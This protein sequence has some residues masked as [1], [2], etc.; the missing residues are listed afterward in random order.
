MSMKRPA[1]GDMAGLIRRKGGDERPGPL[2]AI[3]PEPA[4]KEKRHRLSLALNT[5]DYDQLREYCHRQRLSH[6]QFIEAAVRAALAEK[7]GSR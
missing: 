5:V 7:A 4:E 3:V 1:G 2:P 6:Q